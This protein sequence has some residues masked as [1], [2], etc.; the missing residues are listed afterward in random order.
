MS[1][2]ITKIEESNE[3]IE[4]VRPIEII[5]ENGDKYTLE[6]DRDTVKWAEQRGFRGNPANG[7][8]PLMD[9]PITFTEDI[10]FYS[11]HMHHRNVTKQFTDN[12]LYNVLKGMPEGM[13]ERLMTL[14][15]L[16]YN[17][18]VNNDEDDSKNSGVVVRM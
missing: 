13:L 17:A 5:L 7:Y 14:H 4:E 6:F 9:T 1:E 16:T 12:M 18:L 8:S 11:F 10:F 3:S 2:K 15:A